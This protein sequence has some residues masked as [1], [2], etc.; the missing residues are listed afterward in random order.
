MSEFDQN[1]DNRR[2]NLDIISHI[3][4]SSSIYEKYFIPLNSSEK[5][6]LSVEI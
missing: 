4:K 2:L 6:L 3:R 5:D 1:S